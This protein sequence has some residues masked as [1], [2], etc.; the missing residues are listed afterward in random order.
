MIGFDCAL[1]MQKQKEHI[2]KRID[3][4]GGK[5][6]IEFGGK[7]FDDYH[8]A[9]VLPGYELDAKVKLLL[10]FK[11]QSEII[12]CISAG[13][14]EK[15]KIRSDIGI[16]YDMD[17]LR[18][19]DSLRG[20]G[21]YISSIVITQYTGQ[22]SAD[23]FRKKLEMRG[24][25]VY[26]HRFTK[27]YPTDV[28]LIVSDEG[29][30][31]NP[32]V[33]TTRPLVVVTAPGPGSGKLATSLSQL[34]HEYKR[35]VKAGYAKFETF[36]IWNLPVGHPVNIAYE[37]A[38]AD[39]GDVNMIDP[40]HLEAYG[41]KAVNYNRDVDAFPLVKMILTKI[42]GNLKTYQSP[43]DMG[44][45]MVG[46][47][48][49]DDEAVQNAARQ[50]IIRR[51]Y[52]AK[53][54]YKKGILDGQTAQ[55]VELLMNRLDIKVEDRP[56]VGRCRH[57]N[58]PEGQSV[59]A[60]QLPSGR[61]ITGRSSSLMNA[62]ASVL[63]NAVKEL[64]GIADGIHLISP[65]VLEP[66]L[67]L[68][69]EVL[70]SRFPVL[71]VEEVLLA[72]SICAATNPTAELAVSHLSKLSGADCHSTCIINQTDEEIYRKLGISITCEPEFPTKKL[73]FR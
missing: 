50:E 59:V 71:N 13:D 40:F 15:N 47:C 61:V 72:M 27:G 62:T 14:I 28:N 38:T 53:C 36:P 12:I 64:S 23:T 22:P 44:V 54:D 5:L 21:L 70:G 58:I 19:I 37:A 57:T 48:I 11:E 2:V 65:V 56:V 69:R 6:Y 1:Y 3:H 55:R 7:L 66:M 41:E 29:Y 24:E 20:V 34:Y 9:R 73:Y 60:M 51:F 45:N 18:L 31:A 25:R 49:S 35:G 10:E 4:F 63:L 39:L 43:T 32:Y 67:R 8:A 26:I 30:G 17:A 33:E 68:K 46:L 42:T 52:R 16:T